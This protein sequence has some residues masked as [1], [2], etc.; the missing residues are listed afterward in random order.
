MTET[1]TK[2]ADQNKFNRPQSI[3]SPTA[4]CKDYFRRVTAAL[5]TEINS[6]LSYAILY[7]PRWSP[8]FLTT[9]Q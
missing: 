2:Q 5:S 4:I 9:K 6:M 3:I 7:N 8:K 1:L